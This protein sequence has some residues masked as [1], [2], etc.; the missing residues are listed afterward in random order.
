MGEK[1]KTNQLKRIKICGFIVRRRSYENFLNFFFLAFL[2][3]YDE[4]K[5]AYVSPPFQ[6]A[7]K[8]KQGTIFFFKIDDQLN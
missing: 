3:I 2:S 5:S 7:V 8:Q 6:R 1:E 4:Q